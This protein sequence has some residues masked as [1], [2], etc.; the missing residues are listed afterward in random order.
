MVEVKGSMRSFKN[1]NEILEYEK[2]ENE[3]YRRFSSLSF[4]DKNEYRLKAHKNNKANNIIVFSCIIT[5]IL[6]ILNFCNITIPIYVVYALY[7]ITFLTFRFHT[8]TIDDICEKIIDDYNKKLIIQE[9]ATNS[10][11]EYYNKKEAEINNYLLHETKELY[12]EK[13]LLKKREDFV[14]G[15]INGDGYIFNKIPSFIADMQAYDFS[16]TEKHLRSKKHPAH[17][18]AE[19]VEELKKRYKQA[20]IEAKIATYKLQALVCV[21]PELEDFIGEEENLYALNEYISLSDVQDDYDR[22]RF[23]ISKDEYNNMTTSERNQLALDRYINRDKSKEEIGAEYE[24]C[25]AR[26]LESIGHKVIEHGALYGLKDLGRDLICFDNIN[27][28]T[29]IIQC[30]YWSKK[31]AI[32]ENVI[33]QLYGSAIAYQIKERNVLGTKIIPVLMIPPTSVIS[34][35][36]KDFIK[37]LGIQ[38]WKQNLLSDFPRIKCN[39]N[40]GN[41]IYHLPFDQQYKRTIIDKPGEFYATTVIEAEAA[42]FRR[43]M[44]HINYQ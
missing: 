13:E 26:V 35:T 22:V 31:R 5:S 43:A 20:V 42:G 14:N 34:D 8:K 16:I 36:A 28:C 9:D 44:R 3:S 30:K 6:L 21:F 24:S 10:L 18:K 1:Y 27:G 2:R 41:K 25:C 40:N 38:V 4:K 29:Y 33:M 17:K 32:K 23:Y 7:Y 37:I 39:I 12:K 19:E 11:A 15:V